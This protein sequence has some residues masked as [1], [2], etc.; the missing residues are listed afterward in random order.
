MVKKDL[1]EANCM[2]TI[3]YF[4]NNKNAIIIPVNNKNNYIIWLRFKSPGYYY[5]ECTYPH[6]FVRVSLIKPEYIRP[7]DDDSEIYL[8]FDEINCFIDFLKSPV[9]YL[10]ESNKS[11]YDFILEYIKEETNTNLIG[12]CIPDYYNLI[13]KENM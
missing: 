13:K 1:G 9:K 2:H 3:L 10:Y 7:I 12:N 8:T 11:V 4:N 5:D 6:D